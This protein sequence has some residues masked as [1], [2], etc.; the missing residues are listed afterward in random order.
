MQEKVLSIS[1]YKFLTNSPEVDRRSL[2]ILGVNL[3]VVATFDHFKQS[4]Y[5]IIRHTDAAV[6]G[7]LAN[8]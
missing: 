3:D 4:D 6:T 2:F 7:W 1:S 5:V 8:T